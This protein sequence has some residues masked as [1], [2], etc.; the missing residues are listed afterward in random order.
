M[1]MKLVYAFIPEEQTLNQQVLS[2][3][4]GVA[5]KQLEQKFPSRNISQF[6]IEELALTMLRKLP[7]S[8][9]D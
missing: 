4:R 8:F 7:T 2:V 1:N 6:E 9:W 5:K 3:A